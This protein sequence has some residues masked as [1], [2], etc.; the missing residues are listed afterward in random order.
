MT[1]FKMKLHLWHSKLECE[2]FASFPNLNTFLDEDGLRVDADILDIIK[3]HVLVLHA[4]IQR[5]FPDLQNLEKVHYFITN[6]FAIS[7]VDVPLE[8]YVIQEQFIDLLIDRGAKNAFRNMCCSEFWIEM[9]L[10]YPDVAKLALKFIVPFATTYECETAFATLLAIETKVRNK[11]N[12]AHD[13]R[14]ALSKT[15]PNIEDIL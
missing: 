12:V 5:Y 8:D 11:L 1:A 3:Q 9:T 13:M 7:V 14:V 6:P 2:Y 4:E 15:Q 10:S